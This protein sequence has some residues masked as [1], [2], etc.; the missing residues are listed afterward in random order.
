MTWP[1]ITSAVTAVESH[2]L[3][4]LAKGKV[5]LEV[6]S[7]YGY[8]TIVMARVAKRVHAVDWHRGD[9]HAGERDT[10]ATLWANLERYAVRDRVILHVGRAQDVLPVLRPGSFDLAFLDAFHT[11]EA[12]ARDAALIRP[13]LRRGGMLAFHD[14]GRFG[15][16]EA[17]DALGVPVS[18]TGTL[19]VVAA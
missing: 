7:W 14:Y 12:V 17:V 15:V 10:L 2:R 4:E 6:G 18:L 19:A 1:E 11:T 3:A 9:A 8:S 13:L 16:K 5:V